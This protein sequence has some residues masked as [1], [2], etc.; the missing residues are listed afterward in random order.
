MQESGV[1]EPPSR[2]DY[3]TALAVLLKDLK[4]V[5]LPENCAN[6]RSGDAADSE[7]ICKLSRDAWLVSTITGA[8]FVLSR[9][10]E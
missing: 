9:K 1:I 7:S 8:F 4:G 5:K 2:D 3:A 6:R 10:P